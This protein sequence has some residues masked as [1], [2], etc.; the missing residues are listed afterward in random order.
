M[1][2][3]CS[4]NSSK[5]LV[6][7]A[8]NTTPLVRFGAQKKKRNQ[9]RQTHCVPKNLWQI[10]NQSFSLLWISYLE[11]HLGTFLK[12]EE[13]WSHLSLRADIFW[14]PHRQISR[15][16]RHTHTGGSW[17]LGTSCLK[18]LWIAMSLRNVMRGRPPT[19]VSCLDRLKRLR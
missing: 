12:S 4:C 11:T 8:S 14:P 3:R 16:S 17:S 6:R 15:W 9:K 1:L 5:G 18:L 10:P 19:Q 13:L 2:A 7:S